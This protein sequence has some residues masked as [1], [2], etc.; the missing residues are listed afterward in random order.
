MTRKTVAWEK[1]E[2]DF[3]ETSI[4]NAG[5]AA[6]EREPESEFSSEEGTGE[7]YDLSNVFENL[8]KMV[9]TPMGWYQLN[10]KMSPGRQFDCWI[11][12]ANFDITPSVRNSLEEIPGVEVL[13]ILTR[14]RFFIGIGRMFHFRDVRVNIE[15]FILSS[16][17]VGQEEVV[18]SPTVVQI[19]DEVKQRLEGKSYWAIFVF[20][21]GEVDYV[22]ADNDEDKTFKETL[23]MYRNARSI[24]GGLIIQSDDV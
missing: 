14:Y 8:P 17:K 20:P 16:G 2:E 7:L 3:P 10:D 15:K 4:E 18:D 24:T 6:P 5:F 12:H 21:N 23:T 19:V 1:W 11:G 13:V 22:S 9:N